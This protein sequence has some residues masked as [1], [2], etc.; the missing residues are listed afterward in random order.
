MA[1]DDK[2][3]AAT[4]ASL[5]PTPIA[6]LGPDLPDQPSRVVRGQVTITWPYNSVNKTL[7]VLIAEPDVRLRRNKGQIRI[8]LSGPSA[9]AVSAC[10]LGAGDELLFALAGAEWS[11]DASPG[12]IPGAR[13][14]WQLQFG[15]KL[16]LQVTSSESGEVRH[17][18]I[19]SPP[20][21]EPDEPPTVVARPPSPAPAPASL[22]PDIPSTA[23]KI[24]AA[25]LE[26]YPS[27]AFMKRAR[28]SYGALFEGGL[29]IFE[30]DGGIRGRGRKRTRFG[31]NSGAW[32]YSSRSPSP[33]RS[34]PTPDAVET[35]PGGPVGSS[36][37]PAMLDEACQTSDVEMEDSDPGPARRSPSDRESSPVSVASPTPAPRKRPDVPAQEQHA[38]LHEVGRSSPAPQDEATPVTKEQ[39]PP[40]APSR[41]PEP[42]PEAATAGLVVSGAPATE[43]LHHEAQREEPSPAPAQP[44]NLPPT[45]N[46][47]PA[48]EIPL[49]S[50]TSFGSG[51]S[52][53]A[54]AAARDS[55]LS[56]ADQVRFGFSHTPHTEPASPSGHP[57]GAPGPEPNHAIHD[58]YPVSYLDHVHHPASY[59]DIHASHDG[60]D[61]QHMDVHDDHD[62]PHPPPVETYNEGQWEMATQAPQYNPIEGGHFGAD[63]LKEGV[64]LVD[65][66]SFHTSDVDPAK[67]PEGFRSYGPGDAPKKSPEL[68]EEQAVPD[69]AG[70]KSEVVRIDD[71]DESE[72]EGGEGEEE[73]AV[74]AAAAA[75]E[76]EEE[77][78]EEEE[79]EE[80]D[81]D[82]EADDDADGER[83]EEGVYDQRQYEI[84]SDDEEGS[85]EEE[86]ELELEAEERY[87]NN[88]V[89]D[90]DC[91][92]ENGDVEDGEDEED[93]ESEEDEYEGD[94][95][96]DKRYQDEDEDEDEEEEEEDE[97][98]EEEEEEDE[99]DYEGAA[100]SW[101]RRPVAVQK[102]KEP[103]VISLL[104]DSE[105]EAPPA[106]P[107]PA[108]ARQV[109]VLVN[110]KADTNVA[111]TVEP[112]SESEVESEANHEVEAKVEPEIQ[113]E[114][115]EEAKSESESEDEHEVELEVEQRASQEAELETSPPAEEGS[116]SSPE[117]SSREESLPVPEHPRSEDQPS[118][119]TNE[120]ASQPSPDIRESVETDHQEVQQTDR[121]FG[122][123]HVVDFAFRATQPADEHSEMPPTQET[124]VAAEPSPVDSQSPSALEVSGAR[125][126]SFAPEPEAALS[127]SSSEGLFATAPRARSPDPATAVEATDR[128]ERPAGDEATSVP[129]PSQPS[130]DVM[131]VEIPEEATAE[132]MEVE[133]TEET[134]VEPMEVE[135]TATDEIAAQALEDD[136]LPDADAVSFSSQ[137]EMVDQPT[138]DEM[139]RPPTDTRHFEDA[140]EEDVQM[141]DAAPAV[142]PAPIEM[143]SS[144]PQQEGWLGTSA[145]SSQDVT[146][147]TAYET[148]PTG[149]T[150][151]QAPD[152]QEVPVISE[153]DASA[154]P[155]QEVV[156]STQPSLATKD[157]VADADK[158]GLNDGTNPDDALVSATQPHAEPAD[159]TEP[160]VAPETE[161]DA[162]QFETQP[163]VELH[164]EPE[165]PPQSAPETAIPPSSS[166]LPDQV[167]PTAQ[168]PASQ[169]QP[170]ESEE[171]PDDE[172]LL[173][174]QLSQEQ[175]RALEAAEAATR[176]GASPPS[177]PPDISVSLA[178]QAV[179]TKRSTRSTKAAAAA[180]AAAAAEQPTRASARLTHTRSNSLRSNDTNATG[181]SEKDNEED[182]SVSLARAALASPSRRG[183]TAAASTVETD[184]SNVK[185]S[186]TTTTTPTATAPTVASLKS[187]LLRLLRTSFSECIPLKSL[188][189]HLDKFPN[190]V[191]VVTSRPT[192]PARA[193]GGPREYFLSFHATDPSVAPG[194]VVEV[195]LY[196]PHVESLPVVGPG[197]VVLL[198]RFQV[199]AISKK[200]FGL[201][202]GGESAWAVWEASTLEGKGVGGGENEMMAPQIRGPP[203]EDWHEYVGY[204][205]T[206]RE[207]WG[208]VMGDGKA[209]QKLEGAGRKLVEAGGSGG[210]GGGK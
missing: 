146:T 99:E 39:P 64:G 181:A 170:S 12:R 152:V 123:T 118:P 178:R 140:R 65:H 95:H 114:A 23:R 185:T 16:L 106:R 191:V 149:L 55:T 199:K 157:T 19:D 169:A 40:V 158:E 45:S 127:E 171:E 48:T 107:A 43:P 120:S 20:Q 4:L 205:K 62:L 144:G 131:E 155:A 113:S 141:T 110:S 93:Y 139:E 200:G 206:M 25:P 136:S 91:D 189:T 14:E 18:N 103:V 188:Q 92:D 67:V 10:G 190:V 202:T 82:A 150:Q 3:I 97:E 98:E 84:P 112:E 125:R 72:E 69:E 180:A 130:P 96:G 207:W 122:T 172:T 128:A 37:K 115:D 111:T 129:E 11:K 29:D 78:E 49:F 7:A 9:V 71:T 89:Y 154:L 179:A 153:G 74:A 183:D 105:D 66:E 186:T 208:L 85:S 126:P 143:T 201:R 124:T 30:E 193:K 135:K 33:E 68:C 104:S 32:R 34:T 17:I 59:P 76:E 166:Q 24:S 15:W 87:G 80:D 83:I 142:S 22:P 210:G 46:A 5:Q 56:L 161:K 26:E 194:K 36:P 35:L 52:G 137:V 109:P 38:V 42:G 182:N 79:G 134:A 163:I 6:Q 61:A 192:P 173:L 160:T 13:V 195:Q 132:P 70:A 81:E 147:Q 21:H 47:Q 116:R 77:E 145:V 100:G 44:A 27:P 174:E 196:R 164:E 197:D 53:F 203:V 101:H 159:Y 63:A 58:P 1:S 41:Q 57:E 204:V 88:A 117:P 108:P 119:D 8:V 90:E 73:E 148:A 156:P 51:F 165:T 151:E 54:G 28:M 162:S 209:R 2:A 184:S 94:N 50:P 176:R 177:S 31:R 102:P 167:T 75:A 168:E 121:I 133:T 86:E 187:N 138:G 175:A 60:P 198:Q